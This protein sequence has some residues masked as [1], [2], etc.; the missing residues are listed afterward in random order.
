MTQRCGSQRQGLVLSMGP[1]KGP[2]MPL[3]SATSSLYPGYTH[4]SH[5]LRP[6]VT[7]TRVASCS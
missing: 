2:G 1:R 3:S 5:L 6:R 7:V 4:I